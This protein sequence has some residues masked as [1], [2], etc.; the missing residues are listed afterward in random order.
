MRLVPKWFGAWFQGRGAWRGSGLRL[1]PKGLKPLYK[2]MYIFMIFSGFQGVLRVSIRQRKCL[3]PYQRGFDGGER[4]KIWKWRIFMGNKGVKMRLFLEVE[5]GGKWPLEQY[6]LN[7][8]SRI[9]E[10]LRWKK[11]WRFGQRHEAF[12]SLQE[13]TSFINKTCFSKTPKKF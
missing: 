1:S 12:K 10:F 6:F 5:G 3:K 7:E 8:I 4:G 13:I 2:N 11:Q 9:S